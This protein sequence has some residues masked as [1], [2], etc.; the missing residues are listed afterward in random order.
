MAR[1]NVAACLDGRHAVSFW[2]I[3]PAVAAAV[4]EM[5]RG[6][7]TVKAGV[8]EK[9]MAARRLEPR[10]LHR[11]ILLGAEADGGLARRA[12]SRRVAGLGAAVLGQVA[13]AWG[14]ETVYRL[15]AFLPAIGLLA[16]FLP[17]SPTSV[18]GSWDGGRRR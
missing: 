3:D 8:V 11:G 5:V 9:I 6:I 15:C 18:P 16:A 2:R 14:I 12:V 1:R 4:H 7:S 17:E 10:G 13:D